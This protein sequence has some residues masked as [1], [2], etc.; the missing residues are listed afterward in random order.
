M[1]G[2]MPLKNLHSH[3]EDRIGTHIHTRIAVEAVGTK[4]EADIWSKDNRLFP[5][6]N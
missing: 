4:A 2:N 3:W 5:R 6:Q 1:K